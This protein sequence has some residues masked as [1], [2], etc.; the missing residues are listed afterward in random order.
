MIDVS[1]KLTEG[2][3]SALSC[4]RPCSEHKAFRAINSGHT[5][6]VLTLNSKCF[7]QMLRSKVGHAPLKIG[8]MERKSVIKSSSTDLITQGRLHKDKIFLCL[9]Q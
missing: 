1:Q 3:L 7:H 9:A 8:D 5:G 4:H 2:P 6:P